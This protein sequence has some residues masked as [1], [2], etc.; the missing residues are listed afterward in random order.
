MTPIYHLKVNIGDNLTRKKILDIAK[1]LKLLESP[2]KLVYQNRD[3]HPVY[4]TEN[5]RIRNKMRVEK[6]TGLRP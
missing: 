2:W 5:Q 4:L 3:I 6:T 1:R